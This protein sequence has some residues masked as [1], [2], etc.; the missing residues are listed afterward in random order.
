MRNYADCVRL[1]TI[2]WFCRSEAKPEKGGDLLLTLFPVPSWMR[3]HPSLSNDSSHQNNNTTCDSDL[4][5]RRIRSSDRVYPGEHNLS[6]RG[7]FNKLK[8]SCADHSCICCPCLEEICVASRLS[9]GKCDWGLRSISYCDKF[10]IRQTPLL[11]NGYVM[12]R[13]RFG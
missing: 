7:L 12:V 13:R 5:K 3:V 10:Y 9:N 2:R 8:I 6:F 11:L 1:P 4:P